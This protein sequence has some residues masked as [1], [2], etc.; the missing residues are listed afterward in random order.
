LIFGQDFY[1]I[2]RNIRKAFEEI[3]VEWMLDEGLDF[4][5][6]IKE[7][8]FVQ[9]EI[10]GNLGEGLFFFRS[11]S[12]EFFL[13]NFYSKFHTLFKFSLIIVINEFNP[14]L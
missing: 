8:R 13:F 5:G 6:E 4:I 2:R 7:N 9:I 14:L 12:K 3:G 11:L 10:I 1:K